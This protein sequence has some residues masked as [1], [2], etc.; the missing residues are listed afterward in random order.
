[1]IFTYKA[2]QEVLSGTLQTLLA[3]LGEHGLR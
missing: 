1:M 3:P 2:V